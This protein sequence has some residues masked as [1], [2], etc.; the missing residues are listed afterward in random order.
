[1]SP[2]ADV[3]ARREMFV[4]YAQFAEEVEKRVRSAIDEA[5]PFSIVGCGLPGMTANGGQL[6]L[7]LLEIARG[8]LRESDLTSTNPRNELV[9]LLSDASASGTR[10]F[11]ARLSERI[12]REFNQVPS[13]WV[14]T[15]PNLEE[16]NESA[17]VLGPAV[18]EGLGRRITDRASEAQISI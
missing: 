11:A 4:P 1:V 12:T 8:L 5:A 9:I 13:L 7:R 16:S 6:A 18:N 10:A 3:P 2:I 14:R 15:F 17:S